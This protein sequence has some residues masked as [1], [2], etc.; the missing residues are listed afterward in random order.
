MT[1]F[2]QMVMDALEREAATF[3]PRRVKTKTREAYNALPETF[4]RQDVMEAGLAKNDGTA[5]NVLSRWQKD[6]FIE[7]T[8]NNMFK[9]K[10]HNL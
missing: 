5:R 8:N 10:I 7:S 1:M 6:G 3:T 9:K 2:G 4:T